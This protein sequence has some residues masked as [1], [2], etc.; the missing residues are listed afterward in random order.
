MKKTWSVLLALILM[1]TL[2]AGCSSSNETTTVA[3]NPASTS[4]A[5]QETTAAPAPASTK[6]SLVFALTS[7]PASLVPTEMG[8]FGEYTLA[9]SIFDRLIEQ[10]P[11]GT[12]SPSLAKS[13]DYSEDGATITLHLQ[14]G[15]K[16]HDGTDFTADDVVYSITEAINNPA[17]TSACT[18]TMDHAE[19]IDPHTVALYLTQAYGPIEYCLSYGYMSIYQKA[20]ASADL[21]AYRRAPIGT[22]PYKFVSWDTGD[23]IIVEANP[24]YWNGADFPIK[25]VTYKISTDTSAVLVA[26]EAGDVDFCDTIN[27]NQLDVIMGSNVIATVNAPDPATWYLCMNLS[28]EPFNDENLRK[29]LACCVDADAVVAGALS[30]YGYAN[31]SMCSMMVAQYP[32]GFKSVYQ[33]DLEKAKEYLAAS[34]Y[35]NGVDIV[36]DCM[37]DARFIAISE[38]VAESARQVG[39]NLKIEKTERAAYLE[40]VRTNH[41]YKIVV[42][43]T[44]PAFPDGDYMYSLHHSS[45]IASAKNWGEINDPDIDAWLDEARTSI[46]ESVRT[47]DYQ[48]VIKRMDEKAY[49]IGILQYQQYLIF[50]NKLQGVEPSSSRRVF[51]NNWSWA[52]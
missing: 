18:S 39:I 19:A 23:K 31:E 43:G 44:S 40:K 49:N 47:A 38:I 1:A 41:D 17:I 42:M 3:D 10:A 14:E 35:P 22:G 52:E 34:N 12:L 13:W 25:H 8:S 51:I 45:Y 20:A 7:E 26:L 9:Y 36:M 50:N 16:W 48:N 37:D 32:Q 4:A 46:D 5:G 27:N 30:G 33:Y 11:D 2:F 29:A 28:T 21:D 6:D 24:D 15:V